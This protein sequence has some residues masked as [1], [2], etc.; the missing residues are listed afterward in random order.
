MDVQVTKR[1]GRRLSDA[2]RSE[3]YN[4]SNKHT[5]AQTA[6]QFK[7][8]SSTLYRIKRDARAGFRI[9]R[10]KKVAVEVSPTK[11][12][13]KKG[14]EYKDGFI[15][16][17]EMA[18]ELVMLLDEDVNPNKLGRLARIGAVCLQLGRELGKLGLIG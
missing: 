9:T 17:H 12:V 8:A 16:L 15:D 18:K 3:I 2:D 6:E 13:I 10:G 4:Y 11:A 5:D 1:T 7:I 14:G